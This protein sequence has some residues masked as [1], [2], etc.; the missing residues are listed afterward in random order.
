MASITSSGIGS[1]LDVGSLVAQLVAAERAPEES[2][3]ARMDVKLTTELTA[4][5]QLKGALSTFQS[6]LSVLKDS[7]ALMLRKATV[8]TDSFFSASATSKAAAGSYDVEVVQL[9]QAARL[10]S[11]AFA[12]GATS[13]VGTGTLSI[14]VAGT[15]FDVTIDSTNN[16]LAGIRDA[17]N[18][19]TGNAGVRAT[20]ITA[21]D[22]AHLVLSS[23][24]TGAANTLRVTQSGGDGGLAPLVYDLPNPTTMTAVA[25]QDAIVKVSGFEIHSAT[26]SIEGAIDG[27]AFDLKKQEP[28]TLTRLD[29][30]NDDAA[31]Q[32]KV[33]EFVNAY[34]ALTKQIATLRGYDA[35]NRKAGPLLGDAMLRGIESKLR[36]IVGTPVTGASPNYSTLSSVG[37]AFAADGTLSLD[38]VKFQKAMTADQ[39]AVGKLFGS[40]GGVG[41]QLDEFITGQLG[42]SGNFDVRDKSIAAQRKD[43]TQ[44][45]DALNVRMA[46]FQTRYMAQFTALDAL[47]SKMQSTSTYLTQQLAQSTNI[48]KNAGT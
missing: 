20:I 44:R 23:A 25:P 38:T 1:G 16:T 21:I 15:A 33:S 28:G 40:T 7:A 3:L 24:A 14:T 32:T 11:S 2:R 26:N 30:A 41:R 47:L 43:L 34:N 35:T 22:G 39:Q 12:G 9:A 29:I 6:S 10:S 48:A 18:A 27:V 31:V 36:S 13:V 4:L 8:A 19:A 5:G 37:V 46:A 17:I 45:Q 42:A